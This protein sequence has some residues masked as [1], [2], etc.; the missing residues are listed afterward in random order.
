MKRYNDIEFDPD[1]WEWFGIDEDIRDSWDK[2]FGE[3]NVSITLIDLR[4]YLKTRPD[5]KEKI[6]DKYCGGNWAIF[7]WNMLERNE[8]WRKDNDNQKFY[9]DV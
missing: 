6:I 9:K 3:E 4:E 7:I 2:R 1:I 8:K 5:Y